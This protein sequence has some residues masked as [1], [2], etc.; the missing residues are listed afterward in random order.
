[1]LLRIAMEVIGV[2]VIAG[3]VGAG[4]VWLGQRVFGKQADPAEPQRDTLLSDTRLQD[5]VIDLSAED[6]RVM[7]PGQSAE[8][9][10]A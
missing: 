5:R 7:P 8:Q 10:R 2:L 3:L 4:A 1:M 6:V 9:D